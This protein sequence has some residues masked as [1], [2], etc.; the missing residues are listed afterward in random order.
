MC[1]VCVWCVYVCVRLAVQEVKWTQWDR[2]DLSDPALTLNGLMAYVE[3]QYGAE[4]SMLS[5]GVSI[6]Y[7]N[8]MQ[9]K[10]VLHTCT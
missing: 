7:S 8:F 4:L 9:K 5:H 6:L 1:G 2:I 10:K 3:Q